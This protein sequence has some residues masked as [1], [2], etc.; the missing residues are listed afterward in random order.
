MAEYT[1][2]FSGVARGLQQGLEL[3]NERVKMKMLQQQE[4]MK[5]GQAAY[6]KV[7][8]ERDF[9]ASKMA[10]KGISPTLREYYHNVFAAA[11]KQIMPDI[12][13]PAL[14]D[15]TPED[16]KAVIELGG[17][18]S[19]KTADVKAKR[20][21]TNLLVARM[22]PKV[23]DPGEFLSTVE[24]VIQQNV[25]PEKE[26]L[27]TDLKVRGLEVREQSVAQREQQLELTKEQVLE[28]LRND[29][30][31]G[32][33][34]DSFFA[35]HGEMLSRISGGLIPAPSSR[36]IET[37]KQRKETIERLSGNKPAKQE[38]SSDGTEFV[39]DGKKTYKLPANQIEAFLKSEKGKG[40]KRG[41]ANSTTAST[42]G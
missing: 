30:D 11:Q 32:I 34:P 41:K 33:D 27:E 12:P 15:I 13:I 29:L 19:D 7:V 28:R 3:R 23:S 14:K 1:D 17:I 5:Q 40:F 36:K 20:A 26:A 31:K 22:L 42:R 21:A 38:Q 4:M 6:E 18:W 2:P 16:E 39:N 10:E 25:A 35:K 8:K 24:R 9:A 37:Q